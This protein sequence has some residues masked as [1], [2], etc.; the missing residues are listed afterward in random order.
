MDPFLRVSGVEKAY[1]GLRPFR[2]RDLSVARGEVVTMTGPDSSQASVLVDLL[3]G[4]T[5]PDAGD[6]WVNGRNTRAIDTQEAWLAFLDQF[7][8]VSERVVLLQE[9]TAAQNLAIPLTL[10][11][12]PMPPGVR[13][14]VE[15]L[16]AEVGLA[17]EI[18]DAPVAGV[19][20]DTRARI[21]LGRAV[22]LDPALLLL[23]HPTAGLERPEVPRLARDLRR[24]ASARTI[25]ALAVTADESFAG[26][27]ATRR[28]IWR[29]A[30]GDLSGGAG[31]LDWLRG[32]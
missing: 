7:G 27:A 3:T 4:T 22:A 25:A 8:L 1:G 26:A 5:L 17:A 6:V 2:L 9:L 31:L 11:V 18:L 16:A 19:S 14:R 29:A 23:E 12:D 24:I 28:L 13:R 32:R 15:A 21:R 20:A 10:G 30:S